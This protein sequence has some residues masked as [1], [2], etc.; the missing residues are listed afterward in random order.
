MTNCIE[1][2]KHKVE[3]S[4]LTGTKH[5]NNFLIG[6]HSNEITHTTHSFISSFPKAFYFKTPYIFKYRTFDTRR[7]IPLYTPFLPFSTPKGQSWVCSICFFLSPCAFLVS[8]AKRPLSTYIHHE[9]FLLTFEILSRTYAI[10]HE[11]RKLKWQP[12]V[13]V[14]LYG[15]T[16]VEI[17]LGKVAKTRD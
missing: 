6:L 4:S 12:L 9:I 1:M 17:R 8:D 3:Y 14:P 11:S 7:V 15:G 13:C 16:Y 5:N 10:K 2:Q